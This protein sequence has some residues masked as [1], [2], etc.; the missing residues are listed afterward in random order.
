MATPDEQEL[1]KN[2]NK[3]TG[4]EKKKVVKDVE[5][6]ADETTQKMNNNRLK[7]VNYINSKENEMLRL[8]RSLSD[9]EQ[10]RLIG[11]AELLVEQAN[12]EENVG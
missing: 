11:R 8:F 10:M 3:L 7:S 9:D 5:E 2:Y 6:L 4:E 12:L 1:L